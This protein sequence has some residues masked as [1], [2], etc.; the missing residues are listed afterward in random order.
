MS[1]FFAAALFVLGVVLFCAGVAL[2]Y[3]PA[4]LVA[5]GAICVTLA[6]RTEVGDQ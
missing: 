3:P 2:M 6:V 5:A 4:A 1:V